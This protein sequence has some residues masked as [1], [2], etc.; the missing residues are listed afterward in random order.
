[1]RAKI[2]VRQ[3][4]RQRAGQNRQRQKQQDSR[5][6]NRP[7]EQ[8]HL[9]QGHARRT[10]VQDRHDEVDGTKNGS[11]TGRVKRQDQKIH[12]RTRVTSCTRQ[13]RIQ[14][15]AAAK[16]KEATRARD[17]HGDTGHHEGR[18]S[19]PERDIVHPRERHVRRADHQR[20]KPVTKATDERRHNH[21]E[22]HDQAVIRDHRVVEVLGVLNG[23]VALIAKELHDAGHRTNTRLCQLPTNQARQRIPDDTRSNCEYEI[24]RPDVLV[25]RRQEPASKEARLVVVGV[26]VM[27][28]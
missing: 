10:H 27:S 4:H 21:E 6:Q 14:H 5:H 3:K 24:K 25:V 23:L 20:D 12:R 17:D 18:D 26:V 13:R 9:V 8:R 1:M 22:D 16:T 15:P 2:A 11:D 28:D 7:G 19:Q